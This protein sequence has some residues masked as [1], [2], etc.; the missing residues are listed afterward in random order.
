MV[1]GP[2]AG[3]AAMIPGPVAGARP[4]CCSTRPTTRRRRWRAR[5]GR[6]SC[7]WRLARLR[8]V[9]EQARQE[10]APAAPVVVVAPVGMAAPRP[11]AALVRE[12]PGGLLRREEAGAALLR[13]VA[14]GAGHGGL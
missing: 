14:E 9:V 2:P 1:K 10:G 8:S 4:A 7:A 12:E 5:A 6:C 3:A 11:G 13:H